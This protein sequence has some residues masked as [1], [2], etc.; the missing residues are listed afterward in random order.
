MSQQQANQIACR[1]TRFAREEAAGRSPLYTIVA[2]GVANDRAAVNFLLSLPPEKQQPNLLLAAVRHLFGV[3]ADWF[4]FR[5]KLLDN[6]E[7]V[8][9]VMLTHST[10]TNEPARCAT[11]LPV[12]AQL[13]Q[14]LALIEIGASAGLCLLPD[15]YGYSYGQHWIGPVAGPSDAPVFDCAANPHTPVPQVL[16]RVVWR[17]GLDL[18]PLDAADANHRAWLETLVWPEQTQRLADLRAALAIAARQK[19]RVIKGD[20]RGEALERLCGEAPSDVTLV[21]FHTDVPAYVA[22]RT[23]R[24]AFAR[25]VMALC[26]YW[27]A[28][29]SPRAIPGIARQANRRGIEGRFLLSVNA[30]PVAWTDPHGAAIEWLG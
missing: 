7:A 13:P 17:A 2:N 25:R 21:S 29:E 16:P 3:A 22:D 30:T 26:P 6:P 18:H 11:L 19:P 10:Q 9:A 12:L 15:H 8:R 24:E 27:V 1:Y 23:E 28:N 5:Q 14:P 20:L 4:D